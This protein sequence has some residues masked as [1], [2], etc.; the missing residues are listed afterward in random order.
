MLN[1]KIKEKE[2]VNKSDISRFTENSGL[3]ENIKTSAIKSELKAEPDK[4]ENLQTYKHMIQVL[5]LQKL[6]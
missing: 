2:L 6:L 5:L 4:I 3:N 1:A